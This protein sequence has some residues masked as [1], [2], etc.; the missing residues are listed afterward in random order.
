MG[1]K[2][3]FQTVN[4]GPYTLYVTVR[5]PNVIPGVAAVEVRSSGA[6]VTGL[7]VTPLPLTGEGF[8]ASASC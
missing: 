3:V 1:S 8:E 5:P 6:T 2:D 7:K 4:A